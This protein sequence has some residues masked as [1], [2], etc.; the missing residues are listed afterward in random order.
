L[1]N[2]AYIPLA[3]TLQPY[4]GEISENI[5]AALTTYADAFGD[6]VDR[7]VVFL[8]AQKAEAEIAEREAERFQ[9]RHKAAE[10]D[11]FL[12]MVSRNLQKL[13]GQLNM[14]SLQTNS[15]ASPVVQDTAHIPA[16][17]YRA[18]IDLT[19]PEWLEISKHFRR[20]AF[21]TDW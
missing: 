18:R 10:A 7:I 17:F 8:K 3:N 19:W 9:S 16:S 12:V 6:K 20:D 11:A 13:R 5:K 4:H 1:Q 21:G 15:T 14:I 2:E